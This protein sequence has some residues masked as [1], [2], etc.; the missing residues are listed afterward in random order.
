MKK[1]GT[2]AECPRREGPSNLPQFG[3]RH[4]VPRTKREKQIGIAGAQGAMAAAPRKDPGSVQEVTG[5]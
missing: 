1:Q 2:H 4:A 5:R 3:A